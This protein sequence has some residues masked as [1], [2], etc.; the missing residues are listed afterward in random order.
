[1]LQDKFANTNLAELQIV[2]LITLGFVGF[3]RWDE[4]SALDN[5]A[6]WGMEI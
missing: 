3:F 4:L 2:T 5:N 6:S 1:M